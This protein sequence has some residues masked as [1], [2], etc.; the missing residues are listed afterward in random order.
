MIITVEKCGDSLGIRI[1]RYIAEEMS[2]KQGSEVELISDKES[3]ILKPQKK[4]LPH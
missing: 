2:I 4:T 3:I 1:P